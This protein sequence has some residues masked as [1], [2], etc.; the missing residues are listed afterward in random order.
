MSSLRKYFHNLDAEV[1]SANNLDVTGSLN[2]KGITVVS[3]PSG[4]S[5]KLTLSA[6]GV[7][8]APSGGLAEVTLEFPAQPEDGQVMFVSFTQDVAKVK[9][10]S[11]K[12]ANVST[13]GPLVSA[14]D[15][16]LLF[17]NSET[18]K[19]YKLSGSNKQTAPPAPAPTSEIVTKPEIVSPR[20]PAPELVTKPELVPAPPA[21]E[22]VP[23]PDS[24]IKTDE[25]LV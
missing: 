13:L 12:F 1:L 6:P 23:L 22:L 21:P 17:Y 9:F 25:L 14:G 10:V 20:P 18:G 24:V 2:L 16:I 19:W 15:S 7:I 11:G 3:P 5:V 8:V 4:S